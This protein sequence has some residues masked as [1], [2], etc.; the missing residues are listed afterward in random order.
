MKGDYMS[1][2]ELKENVSET[3]ASIAQLL[4]KFDWG[5]FSEDGQNKIETYA[6]LDDCFNIADDLKD[7]AYRVADEIIKLEKEIKSFIEAGNQKDADEKKEV[8]KLLVRYIRH[9]LEE[10]IWEEHSEFD[11]NHYKRGC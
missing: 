4:E 9:N 11:Y 8:V 6:I 1:F 5:F 10:E 7:L 3:Y 2:K